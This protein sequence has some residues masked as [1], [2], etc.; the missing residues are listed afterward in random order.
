MIDNS[1]KRQQLINQTA[2]K[3]SKVS[4]E[5]QTVVSSKIVEFRRESG[6]NVTKPLVVRDQDK[7]REEKPKIPMKNPTEPRTDQQKPTRN[8]T[9]KMTIWRQREENQY[10]HEKMIMCGLPRVQ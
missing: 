6:Q 5:L 3:L 4:L 2:E 8:L 9:P 1:I 10:H 7:K